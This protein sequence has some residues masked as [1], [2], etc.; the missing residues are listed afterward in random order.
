MSLSKPT[1][2][3]T[4]KINPHALHLGVELERVLA[5]LAAVARLLVTTERRSGIEH[6]VGIDPNDSGFHR[7]SEPMR[8][9]DV[10]RPDTRG[11]SVHRLVRLTNQIVIIIKGDH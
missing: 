2:R 9:R 3:L 5:H 10:A 8:T 1:D 6:V 7:A 4:R 11:Q